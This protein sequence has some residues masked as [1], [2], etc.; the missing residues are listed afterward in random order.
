VLTG[1]SN[2]IFTKEGEE[3]VKAA[4]ARD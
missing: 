1:R 3:E 2:A 4:E